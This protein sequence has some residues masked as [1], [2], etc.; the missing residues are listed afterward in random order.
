[1]IIHPPPLL[2][3]P[4]FTL[5]VLALCHPTANYPVTGHP[6]KTETPVTTGVNA[7]EPQID[8]DAETM[9][10]TR[11]HDLVTE[12]L[13]GGGNHE[14]VAQ[15]R[16]TRHIVVP[17]R[18]LLNGVVMVNETIHVLTVVMVVAM[19]VEARIIWKGVC[20]NCVLPH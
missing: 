7:A 15:A 9:K 16:N 17:N 11:G 14:S 13:A 8:T 6:I 1:M 19:V 5:R 10:G 4:P 12:V 18:L 3:W 20:L 2:S